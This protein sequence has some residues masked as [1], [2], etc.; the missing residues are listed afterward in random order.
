MD[1]KQY[2]D[3][4]PSGAAALNQR[5]TGDIARSWWSVSTPFNSPATAAAASAANSAANA[6]ATPPQSRCCCHRQRRLRSRRRRRRRRSH[7]S[8]RLQTRD[9]S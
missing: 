4:I 5:R 3:L 8:R 2:I 9:K 6:A 1:T 7:Y